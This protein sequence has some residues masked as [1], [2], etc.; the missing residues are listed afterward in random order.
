[1][2]QAVRSAF[3]TP[4]L[5]QGGAGSVQAADFQP[6]STTRRLGKLLA[7]RLD[8]LAIHQLDPAADLARG[9]DYVPLD[10][11][12][13]EYAESFTAAAA[14][15]PVTVI[16]FCSAAPLA[17]RIAD[18]LAAENDVAV[19]LARSQGRLAGVAGQGRSASIVVHCAA[20]GRR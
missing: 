3:P 11:I 13:A 5:T 2:D 4:R 10:R 16:G 1:M 14:A 19:L 8:D 17:L 7:D 20:A 15:G 9:T 6:F 12:A 18:R